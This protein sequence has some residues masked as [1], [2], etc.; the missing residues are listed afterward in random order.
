MV[1]FTDEIHQK[2]VCRF[3]YAKEQ[4]TV[5]IS[6]VVYIMKE[7]PMIKHPMFYITLLTYICPMTFLTF[8]CVCILVLYILYTHIYTLYTHIHTYCTPILYTHT[9]HPYCTPILYTQTL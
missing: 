9:V 6:E 5:Q 3:Q 4:L 7:E 2:E 1:N 8:A